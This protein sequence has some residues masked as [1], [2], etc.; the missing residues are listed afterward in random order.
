MRKIVV[1]SGM[2]LLLAAIVPLILVTFYHDR[3]ALLFHLS[4]GTE[5]MLVYLG[6]FWGAMMGCMGILVTV[7]GLARSAGK[8]PDVRLAPTA[9][10]LAVAILYYFF[11]FYTS[12]TSTETPKLRP[13]ET[14][15]I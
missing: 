13:G 10:I 12:L 9:I 4:P 7:I 6:F 15:T 5:V 2:N 3:I 11:L 14:I 8:G 1:R